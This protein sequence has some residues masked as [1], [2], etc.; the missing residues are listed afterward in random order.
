MHMRKKNMDFVC[1]IHSGLTWNNHIRLPTKKIVIFSGEE[2]VTIYQPEMNIPGTHINRSIREAKNMLIPNHTSVIPN[3]ITRDEQIEH[4]QKKK[5]E[6]KLYVLLL[7]SLAPVAR[8]DDLMRAQKSK[9]G[10]PS[11]CIHNPWH[12]WQTHK[13]HS[14]DPRGKPK[15][16]N[17]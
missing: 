7:H 11:C 16:Q 4:K 5:K 8:L 9:K 2:V 15:V 14:S 6:N 3:N 1:G 17:T 10:L 13:T 12:G